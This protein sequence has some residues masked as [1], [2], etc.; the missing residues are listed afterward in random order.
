MHLIICESLLCEVIFSFNQLIV[1]CLRENEDPSA[2]YGLNGNQFFALKKIYSE[3]NAFSIKIYLTSIP[4]HSVGQH[5]EPYQVDKRTHRCFECALC[6]LPEPSWDLLVR[7][8]QFSNN[9]HQR[10]RNHHHH[11]HCDN[12]S[13]MMN[14][15]RNCIVS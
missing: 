11:H 12:L 7:V 5:P 13:G 9:H 3:T 4:P 6:W 10:H 2:P 1:L 15:R 14:G 8:R